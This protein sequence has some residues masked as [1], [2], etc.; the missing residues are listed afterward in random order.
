MKVFDDIW[1]HFTPGNLAAEQKVFIQK[2]T[3]VDYCSFA[4]VPR[5]PRL[6]KWRGEY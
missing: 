5:S 4:I 2:A 6:K 3:G 1:T